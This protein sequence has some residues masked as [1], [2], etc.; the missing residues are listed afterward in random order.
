MLCWEPKLSLVHKGV[1]VFASILVLELCYLVSLFLVVDRAESA[2]S[3]QIACR[4]LLERAQELVTLFY[5]AQRC[6]RKMIRPEDDRFV[7][8]KREAA[9]D[10]VQAFDTGL[11]QLSL[12]ARQHA[13]L[14]QALGT[15]AKVSAEIDDLMYWSRRSFGKLLPRL[16]DLASAPEA[17]RKPIADSIY[18]DER[19]DSIVL[20]DKLVDFLKR[21]QE[22]VL[23][24]PSPQ[25]ELSRSLSLGIWAGLIL[26]VVITIG[27]IVFFGSEITRKLEIMSANTVRVRTG[28]QLLPVVSGKDE[29][30]LLD[31]SFHEMAKKLAHQ[32]QLRRSYILLFK[33]DLSRPLAK[34][35]ELLTTLGREN[36]QNALVQRLTS[37][38][39]RSLSRL[40]GIVE[41]LAAVYERSATSMTLNIVPVK[42]AD[43]VDRAIEA[44]AQLASKHEIELSIKI[45]LPEATMMNADGDR[46]V[47]VLVNLLSNSIK[48][49]PARTKVELLLSERSS[50]VEFSVSD[51]GRGIPQDQLSS[52]FERFKQVDVADGRRGVGTGLGLSICKQIIELHGGKIAVES[53]LNEGSRFWFSL[54]QQHPAEAIAEI[55]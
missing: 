51:Q 9:R 47:Q 52:I 18:K 46:I 1:L 53:K 5:G 45:D 29:L 39:I 48:Y 40:I 44:V 30:A 31:H 10:F 6:A 35:K 38:A 25:L 17:E 14:L 34:V 22:V 37:S 7:E 43:I 41:D 36:P 3:T 15:S 4:Q 49:S 55:V 54:P 2:A 13:Q 20:E 19:G 8:D 33:E 27:V 23:A 24:L 32:D 28:A 42:P 16:D 26:N 21:Q 11:Q 50:A 12:Q